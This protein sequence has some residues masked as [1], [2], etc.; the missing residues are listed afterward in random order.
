VGQC[1]CPLPSH[2]ACWWWSSI[3][4]LIVFTFSLSVRF[5]WSPLYAVPVYYTVSG[6]TV[7]CW[8]YIWLVVARLHRLGSWPLALSVLGWEPG[9]AHRRQWTEQSYITR[10][11]F[12][13]FGYIFEWGYLL[14]FASCTLTVTVRLERCQAE[15]NAINV[16]ETWK[17]R[18]KNCSLLVQAR[19]T[20]FFVWW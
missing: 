1:C 17:P 10:Y 4:F 6:C 12:L 20:L 19:F 3:S 9:R 18:W 8:P 11:P 13:W 5:L 7:C 16:F 15:K 2:T 14:Q